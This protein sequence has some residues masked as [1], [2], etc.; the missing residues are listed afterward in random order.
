[1]FIGISYAQTEAKSVNDTIVKEVSPIK[2]SEVPSESGE[3]LN[4]LQ[5]I[6]EVVP[7]SA[8]ITAYANRNDSLEK[9]V[10]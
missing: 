7:T 10:D 9:V 8:K 1:M 5:K 2:A 3:L 6:N 4:R